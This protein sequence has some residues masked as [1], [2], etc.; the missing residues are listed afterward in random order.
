MVTVKQRG[1]LKKTLKFLQHVSKASYKHVL[2][3]YGEEGVRALA[4]ATPMDSG[5]T[6]ASWGYEIIEEGNELKI[7]WTNSNL[8]DGWF[9]IALMLQYG[10]GTGTGGWIEGRDY[11][12]P[13]IRPIFD[14]MADAAWRE[15]TNV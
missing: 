7:V 9:P 13:A 3:K 1:D 4:S 15:V 6:A 12:N 10:H 11:I 2:S 14:K 8:G 5:A